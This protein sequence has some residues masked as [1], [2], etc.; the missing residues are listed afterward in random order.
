[1]D[2]NK[3][4]VISFAK[5]KAATSYNLVTRP[6]QWA[7][8]N[9][10]CDCTFEQTVTLNGSAANIKSTVHMERGDVSNATDFGPMSQELPAV[11]S[12][13]RFYRLVTYANPWRDS[14]ASLRHPAVYS[15]G[16]FYRLVAYANPWRDSFAS[17]RH[18]AV[19]PQH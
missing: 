14:L 9:V 18:P 1:M 13:G 12:T 8:H 5:S 7:C 19:F 2:G 11:Y 3:G 4:R 17:L 15:T 10:S 6:L 16:R